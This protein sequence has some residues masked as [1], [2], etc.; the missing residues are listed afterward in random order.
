M[1]D[2]GPR[3]A[4]AAP[5]PLLGRTVLRDQVRNVLL[6]RIVSRHYKPGE[7]LVRA[8]IAQEFGVSQ[9]PV[10]EALCELQMLRLVSAEPFRGYRVREVSRAELIEVY[11]IRAALEQVAAREAAQRLGGDVSALERENRAMAAATDLR[12]QVEHDVRFHELIIAA[13]GNSRLA[14]VWASLQ[15]EARTTVTALLTSV[16]HREAASSHETIIGALRRQD[17][18][19]AGREIRNH[20]EHFGRLLLGDGAP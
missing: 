9:T 12:V 18:D 5:P 2:A 1:H 13:S 16:D 4:P 7:R 19:A 10:R 3:A 14:V 17:P 11:P 6:E 20:V 15:V 8:R